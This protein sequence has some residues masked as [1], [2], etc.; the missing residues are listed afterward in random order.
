MIEQE[1]LGI[2]QRPDQILKVRN[3][4]RVRG[5]Q[6]AIGIGERHVEILKR[7]LQF[8]GTRLAREGNEIQLGNFLFGRR[9]GFRKPGGT[10]VADGKLRFDFRRIDQVQTLRETG[11]LN[12]FAFTDARTVR[13]SEDFQKRGAFVVAVVGQCD[14]TCSGRQI[15]ERSACTRQVVDR[16]QQDFRRHSTWVKP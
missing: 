9:V 4:C 14:G 15:G 3:G 1:F 7:R 10:A 2:H 13:S 8:T 16:I 11:R 5:D 12:A 6:R